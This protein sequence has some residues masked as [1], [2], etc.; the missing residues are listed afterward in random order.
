[1]SKLEDRL[2][3]LKNLLDGVPEDISRSLR[4]Y[5]WFAAGGALVSAL[6]TVVS[7]YL[8]IR[9]GE[10]FR[11]GLCLAS[12]FFAVAGLAVLHWRTERF[13]GVMWTICAA[14]IFAVLLIYHF[15]M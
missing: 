10:E 4:P 14:A 2:W 12:L 7:G 3:K 15:Q 6:L 8:W 11:S 1:M 9:K 13:K 5:E